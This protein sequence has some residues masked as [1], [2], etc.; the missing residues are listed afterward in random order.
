MVEKSC[1][2]LVLGG[3]GSGLVAG[4]RAAEDGKKVIILEKAKFLG[5]GM[6]FASTMRTFKSRWQKERNIP[7]Q[8]EKFIREM[9][10]FTMWR[11]DIELVKRAVYATGEFFDWYSAHE[12][13]ENLAKY[14]PRPY[15]FDIP[16]NGQGGP[17]VDKFHNGS[18]R[19]FVN[20]MIEYGK[21]LGVEMLTECSGKHAVIKDGKLQGI[22]ADTPEGETVFCFD[23][24]IIANGS[25]IKNDE[26]VGK[27]LP[28]FLEADVEKNAHQNPAY[29]GEAIT[30]AEEIGAFVDWDSMC[31]RIMGPIAATGD[32]SDLD[33]LAHAR[34]I[35]LVNEDG[36][37]FVA[38]PMVPRIDPFAT[39]HILLMQPHAKSYFVY[40]KDMLE[41]IIALT[42][43]NA[44]KADTDVFGMPP[45]PDYEVVAGWMSDAEKKN[46]SWC[47]IGET[48]EEAARKMGINADNLKATVDKYN[49]C[50]DKG[51]D[52]EFFKEAKDMIALKEGPY[53]IVAGKLSTDGAFGGIRVDKDMKVY[54]NSGEVF[55]NV[56]A[57]GDIASGRH[58][59]DGGVKKQV[60]NDMSWALASGFIAGSKSG[61][62]SKV[63]I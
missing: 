52:T 51:E 62:S 29:T 47:A 57:C 1:D 22:L 53:F 43:A 27:V 61:I 30:I 10:D 4:V 23:K 16:T 24:L 49:S 63:T 15:V 46:P 60:L 50:C 20:V 5:G 2:V 11:L 37:R 18:G 34:E 36:K 42:K 55:D 17:Q 8:S 25:W 19:M 31:L 59:V 7:D 6:L 35:I 54:R 39:G 58:I 26:I 48:I 32:R 13:E 40:S 56:Y 41:K 38:E 14:E 28:K 21:S 44:A 33:N 12:S 9:M 3:G 45:L